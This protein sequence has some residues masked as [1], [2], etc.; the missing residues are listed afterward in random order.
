VPVIPAPGEAKKGEL[1]V[2]GQTGLHSKTL[3]Q[4]PGRFLKR[5][6]QQFIANI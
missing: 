5:K 3:S 4:K 2:G 1:P 6:K